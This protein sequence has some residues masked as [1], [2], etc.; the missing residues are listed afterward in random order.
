MHQA[1]ISVMHC[2]MSCRFM[3]LEMWFPKDQALSRS[4]SH[5]PAVASSVANRHISAELPASVESGIAVSRS[6]WLQDFS[7]CT[8]MLA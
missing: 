4:G 8:G 2:V 6:S 5:M 3:V 7:V 1:F